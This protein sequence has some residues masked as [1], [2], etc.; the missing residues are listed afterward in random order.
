MIWLNST[1]IM[2]VSSCDC[3]YLNKT[4]ANRFNS[5]KISCSEKQ[6]LWYCFIITSEAQT[7]GFLLEFPNTP[8]M[9]SPPPAL[10]QDLPSHHLLRYTR[11]I[12]TI[13][14]D[15]ARPPPIC[16]D[17]V[18]PPAAQPWLSALSQSGS[19]SRHLTSIT[20]KDHLGMCSHCLL[21]THTHTHTH[22]LSHLS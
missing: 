13:S 4:E 17:V 10:Q 20:V 7:G 1:C 18:C 16:M 9:S 21:H 22:T 19:L 3:R 2:K 14:R 6:L 12:L 5:A 15:P 11:S 8:C